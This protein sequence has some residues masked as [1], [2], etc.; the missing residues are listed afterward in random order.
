[1]L[2]F[3]LSFF[4]PS[5]NSLI[6]FL[7]SSYRVFHDALHFGGWGSTDVA[8]EV[9][10]QTPRLRVFPHL[11]T[12]GTYDQ[13][14]FTVHVHTCTHAGQISA[15]YE[16]PSTNIVSL[17]ILLC[18]SLF[19]VL[20]SPVKRARLRVHARQRSRPSTCYPTVLSLWKEGMIRLCYFYH[21]I[22]EILQSSY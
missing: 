6:C 5:K 8:R 3:F 21:C 14:G 16:S 15:R 19:P 1:M 12:T 22:S 2:S 20:C 4:P 7:I 18:C 11:H 10:F 13:P 17:C 9:A